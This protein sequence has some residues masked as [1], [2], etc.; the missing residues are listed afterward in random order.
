[1][2]K[3]L[4]Q[5]KYFELYILDIAVDLVKYSANRDMMNVEKE[6]VGLYS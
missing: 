1:M 6:I 3:K 5:Q 4:D 2:R